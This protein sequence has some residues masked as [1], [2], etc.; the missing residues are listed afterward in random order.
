MRVFSRLS[1][2]LL[3]ISALFFIIFR[4]DS[5]PHKL[6]LFFAQIWSFVSSGSSSCSFRSF[7]TF[8]KHCQLQRFDS[9]IHGCGSSQTSFFFRCVSLLNCNCLEICS[10]FHLHPCCFT[11]LWSATIS[12]LLSAATSPTF[13]RTVLLTTFLRWESRRQRRGS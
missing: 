3:N 12:H 10:C 13:R 5:L 2:L 4:F 1:L 8:S 9:W 11:F 7:H 6:W